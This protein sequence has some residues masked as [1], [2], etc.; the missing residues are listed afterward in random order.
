M[1]TRLHTVAV[2]SAALFLS[3]S[4]NAASVW[5][6]SV[7]GNWNMTANNFELK[8]SI[9]KQGGVGSCKRIVGTLVNTNNTGQSDIEGFYCPASGRINFLREDTK[10]R[11][12]FQVYS[13]NLSVPGGASNTGGSTG[14]CMGGVFSPDVASGTLGEYDF[15]ACAVV[16]G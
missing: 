11:R 9:T 13:G 15:F 7:V 12:T 2:A 16:G 8:L 6:P 5:P 3:V 4:A 10:N 14:T 1:N